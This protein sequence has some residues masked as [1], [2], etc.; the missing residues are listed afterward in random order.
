MARENVSGFGAS[1][2]VGLASSIEV[3]KCVPRELLLSL[4][5]RDATLVVRERANARNTRPAARD[6][7]VANDHRRRGEAYPEAASSCSARPV[8]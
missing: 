2:R 6:G 1:F 8:L 5:P 7:I 3:P 4:A